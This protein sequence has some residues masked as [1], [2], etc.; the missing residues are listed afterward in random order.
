M[1]C[2]AIRNGHTKSTFVSVSTA[3]AWSRCDQSVTPTDS[4]PEPETHERQHPPRRHRR[5]RL[6]DPLRAHGEVELLRLRVALPD[7]LRAAQLGG[8][9][10]GV[11][12]ET[13]ANS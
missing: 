3:K 1:N 7:H 9:G 10:N 11:P 5:L 12:P 4:L 2:A 13:P 8:G 6:S